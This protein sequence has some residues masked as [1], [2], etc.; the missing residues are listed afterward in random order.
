MRNTKPWK[1][2]LLAGASVMLLTSAATAQNVVTVNTVQIFGTIDPAK[3][4]DY[5][6]YM[7][8]VNMYEALTTL[9]ASGNILPFLTNTPIMFVVNSGLAEAN[10]TGDDP[11]VQDYPANNSAGAGAY[12]SP[13]SFFFTQFH[14]RAKGTWASMEWVLDDEIDAWIDEARGTSSVDAQNSIY[15]KIQRKLADN[16]SDVYVLTQLSQQAFSSRLQGFLWVPMQSLE[17]NFHIMKWV[18]D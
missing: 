2:M 15:Q 10:K 8:G 13:D 16:Q 1:A 3:I 4:N 6:E 14:S 17:F 11:W 12:P 18:C 5:T 7:A 9:D